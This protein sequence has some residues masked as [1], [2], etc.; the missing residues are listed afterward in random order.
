MTVLK[1][2]V[3]GTLVTNKIPEKDIVTNEQLPKSVIVPPPT[4]S[5]ANTT[6]MPASSS[7]PQ[8]LQIVSQNVQITIK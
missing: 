6:T 2:K 4:F 1:N 8:N 7:L 3:L 5:T